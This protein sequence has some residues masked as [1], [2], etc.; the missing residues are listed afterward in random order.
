MVQIILL[1]ARP[2]RKLLIFFLYSTMLPRSYSPVSLR[3]FKHRI[4]LYMFFPLRLP[5]VDGWLRDLA[6]NTNIK[7]FKSREIR[8]KHDFD[9]II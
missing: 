6:E 4:R 7:K 1:R 9:S 5:Y 2:V 3:R 8:L